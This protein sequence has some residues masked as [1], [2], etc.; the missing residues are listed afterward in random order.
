MEREGPLLETGLFKL[1][2]SGANICYHFQHQT[3]QE[4]L[5]AYWINNRPPQ[6]QE[7][8]IQTYRDHPR[9]KV[10]IPFLAGIIYK[11]DATVSKEATK[12]F[13]SKTPCQNVVLKDESSNQA[14]VQ[15]IIKSINE[16]PGYTGNLPAV[17]AL[18]QAHPSLL[19]SEAQVEE[20]SEVPLHTAIRQGQIH[21]LKWLV[22]TQGKEVLDKTTTTGLTPMHAAAMNGDLET[23][24]WLHDKDPHLFHAPDNSGHTSMHAAALKGQLEAMQWLHEKDPELSLTPENNGGTSMHFAAHKGHLEAMQWLHEK[25]PELF[26]TPTNDGHTPMHFAA[27]GGQL[28]AMQWLH[29]KDPSFSAHQQTIAIPPCTL[30]L[31]KGNSK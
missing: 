2:G 28:G 25:D 30:P 23:M 24:Q 3:F 10:V 15:L 1:S 31:R 13:F 22:S 7:A 27:A 14:F 12:G 19:R 9:Y 29:E 16:C 11:R 18:F 8:L 21:F 4:Y 6:E 5:A 26:R 17:E 20:I